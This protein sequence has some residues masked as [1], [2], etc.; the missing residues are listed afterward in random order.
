MAGYCH[1]V[2]PPY[3]CGH[4]AE[5]VEAARKGWITRRRNQGQRGTEFEGSEEQ[6]LAS[7]FLGDTV[8]LAHTH[9]EHKNTV[10]FKQKGKWYEL[11]RRTFASFVRGGRETEREQQKLAKSRQREQRLELE[12]RLYQERV[13]NSQSGADAFR[14]AVIKGIQRQGGIRSTKSSSGRTYDRG[15]VAV[16][17]SSIRRSKGKLTLDSARE[18]A[19]ELNESEYR[20]PIQLD[21]ISDFINFFEADSYRRQQSSARRRL[22]REEIAATRTPRK[23]GERRKSA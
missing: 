19:Q 11:P 13:S 17:P 14:A 23:R 20:L 18:F 12:Y 7:I 16:L 8:S 9:P 5:H 1:G 21:T 3:G 15:E 22:L 4:H 10:V 2:N 6:R